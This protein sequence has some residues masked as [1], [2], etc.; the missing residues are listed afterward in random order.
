MVLA[1]ILHHN[2]MV[3]ACLDSGEEEC[4]AMYNSIETTAEESGNIECGDDISEGDGEVDTINKST[5]V[6]GVS[7]DTT[8]DMV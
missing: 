4:A 7:P 8:C 5:V 6:L 3:K 1:V 2:I